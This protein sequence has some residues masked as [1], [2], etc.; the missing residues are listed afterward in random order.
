MISLKSILHSVLPPSSTI[1]RGNTLLLATWV[2]IL[3]TIL[4]GAVRKWVTGPG[5]LGNAIFFGQLLVPFVFYFAVGKS[6]INLNFKTPLVFLIYVVY[7]IVAALNPKNETLSHGLF[8][9]V[10]H[11]AFWLCWLAYYQTRPIFEMEKFTNLFILILVGEVILASL[12]YNLPASHVLN[13]FATGQENETTLGS[14]IRVAGTF[15]YIG[16]FQVWVT[17]YG[18]FIWSLFVR[19][20]PSFLILIVLALS[21][22]AGLVSGSRGAVGYLVMLSLF[23]F[24][25]SGF[26][27][28]KF[29]NLA[30]HL[31]LL[32]IVV[33]YVGSNVVGKFEI[34]Y[35]NFMTRVEA[36]NKVGE[37]EGR[38]AGTFDDV[39]KFRGN[40]P[41]F[42]VGLGST[43]QGANALFGKSSYVKEYGYFESEPARI[44]LEGGFILL[45]LRTLLFLVM[46]RYSSI[47]KLGR[48]FIFV[49][50]INAMVVFNTYQS[51]FFI[52]GVIMVDRAYYLKHTGESHKKDSS[53][54]LKWLSMIKSSPSQKSS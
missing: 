25:Y 11:L 17:L 34:A 5:A 48:L 42:G 33:L 4:S 9:I 32:T 10:L 40:D 24:L 49:L 7:I 19:K 15:S 38:V 51:V 54:K 36:G 8:G 22:F 30:L 27:I 18:F 52:L 37:L 53:R 6:K 12:Q 41:V 31:S 13:K 47:P 46:M 28:K 45:F 35:L 23:G 3:Y 44:V 1:K 29:F 43:Y 21:L 39:I 2:F 50:F 20:S 14:A 26:V 16:G